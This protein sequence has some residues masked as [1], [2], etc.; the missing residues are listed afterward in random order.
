MV[1]QEEMETMKKEFGD[2]RKENNLTHPIVRPKFSMD[3]DAKV[4]YYLLLIV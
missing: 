1:I 2:L 3:G 4:K